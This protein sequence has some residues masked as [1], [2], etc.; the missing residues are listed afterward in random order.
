M[1]GDA[2]PCLA[3]SILCLVPHWRLAVKKPLC[4]VLAHEG[5]AETLRK[6]P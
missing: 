5:R 4:P 2:G 6:A 1:L 3:L